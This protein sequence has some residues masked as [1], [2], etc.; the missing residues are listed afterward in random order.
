MATTAPAPYYD[1][2]DFDID[3]DPY[4]VWKRLRD[5][6]PLYYNEKYEFYA[7]SRY[8]DVENGLVEW[9]TYSSA[10]GSV[11]EIIKAEIA[12]A[13]RHVHLRGPARPRPA[14][15]HP[16]PRLHAAAAWPPS[17]PRSAPTPRARSTRS[18]GSG[19]FDFIADLGTEIPMRTIGMLLGI[20]EEDQQ[21]IRDHIDEGLRLDEGVMPE[22]DVDAQGQT[23]SDYG[24]LHRLA[25]RASLRRPHDRAAHGGVHRR[26]RHGAHAD[27]RRD[28]R[29]HRTAR[30]GRQRDHDPPDRL[31]GQAPGR[32]PRPAR[33]TWPRTR[34][35]S[36][37][38]SRSASATSRPPRCRPAR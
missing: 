13:A 26:A 35:S 32:A 23:D 38:P 31:G 34:R 30:R 9:Q 21:A 14:P 17:S 25:G 2:Y 27:P 16:E 20:P 22:V 33:G 11:L 15:R 4:P 36:R 12:D 29:L 19:G 18:S 7:I 5:E 1:P 8:E 24:G 28:P 37:P 6:A 10:K 3:A